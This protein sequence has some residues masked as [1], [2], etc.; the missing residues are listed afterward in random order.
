[1]L[2][3][4][5]GIM[6]S[7]RISTLFVAVSALLSGTRA[8]DFGYD[9]HNGPQHW[10][11]QYDTCFGKHQSPI[12]INLL[13]VKE[14]KLPPLKMEGFDEQI[15]G[16]VVANNGHTVMIKVENH[17]PPKISDGPLVG[18]YV[19][20]QLHFHWGNNDSVGSEDRINNKSFPMELHI[21]F[22]KK[23]YGDPKGAL[24][25]S[26]GLAVMAFFYEV[27]RH[28]H[29]AYDL[30]TAALQNVTE[31]QSA[32]P[33]ARSLSLLALLP[34]D[35]EHYFT[36]SGS[37]TT[38]PCSEVVTWI[39]Y[40]QPI[41]LA[42]DQINS[43]RE[44]RSDHGHITHN[45]RPLQPIGDRTIFYN[46]E[47]DGYFDK[48]TDVVRKPIVPQ[49]STSTPRSDKSASSHIKITLGLIAI[50]VCLSFLIN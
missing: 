45:F 34:Y 25:H 43:F 3:G 13:S 32:M 42:H 24:E 46:T 40:E 8:Q 33:L 12:N 10:G 18:E 6:Y 37:L 49:E 11:E 17:E 41:R 2:S 14:V 35:L 7:L 27:D 48:S 4:E 19:F 30:V 44:L 28:R 15:E 23:E 20:S 26:D 16:L 29:P 31:P 21:V 22:Y 36:Y 38:P 47:R 50:A 1:M 39:D 9:G 5:F